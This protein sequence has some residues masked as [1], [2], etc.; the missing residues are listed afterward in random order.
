MN[1]KTTTKQRQKKNRTD[2]YMES[3]FIGT[4]MKSVKKK[5]KTPDEYKIIITT[6]TATKSIP[7]QKGLQLRSTLR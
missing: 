4:L 2:K 5:K 6:A 1:R 7:L 3:I